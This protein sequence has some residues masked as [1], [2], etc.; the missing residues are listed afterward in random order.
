[1][2]ARKSRKEALK[3]DIKHDLEEL[4]DAEEKEPLWKF[5]T[6]ECL[7]RKYVHKILRRFKAE[8][9]GLSCRED[10]G[11]VHYLKK[12]EVGDIYMLVRYQPWRCIHL[13][14]QCNNQ[15]ILCL[16][17]ESPRCYRINYISSWHNYYP[18]CQHQTSRQFQIHLFSRWSLQKLY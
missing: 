4:W 13:Q 1:M 16:F 15:Q 12:N 11:T 8:L 6:R 3:E 10:Y 14:V 2:T 17:R 18:T 7:N 5:F 9:H